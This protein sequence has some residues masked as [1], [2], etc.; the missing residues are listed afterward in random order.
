VVEG[1]RLTRR[2]VV[3]AGFL[4]TPKRAL[5]CASS[6]PRPADESGANH[7]ERLLYLHCNIA[8]K[9]ECEPRIFMLLCAQL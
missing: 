7:S 4:A 1:A 6:Q 5:A 8:E 2:F 9:N 3:A